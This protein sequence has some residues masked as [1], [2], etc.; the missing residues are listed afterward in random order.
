MKISKYLIAL[1]LL[2]AMACN[3]EIGDGAFSP[4]AGVAEPN[5]TPTPQPVCD[6]EVAISFEQQPVNP[7]IM[8]ILDKSG[9]MGEPLAGYSGAS[10]WDIMRSAIANIVAN[11]GDVVKFGLLMF[12]WGNRCHDGQVRVN[13]SLNAVGTVLQEMNS[14]SPI[15]GTPTHQ[16][17]RQ[18]RD[19]YDNVP[20]N[21]D[22]RIVLLATDGLPV[23]SSIGESVGMI[24]ELQQRGIQTFV[25]GF[26]FGNVSVDGLQQMANAG[27]TGQIYPADSPQQLSDAFDSILGQVTVPS[28]T[29]NLKQ[30][31]K[32][33]ADI[34]VSLA[35][36][37]LVR[38]DENGWMYSS[39]ANSITLNGEACRSVKGG[40]A[41]AIEVDLGCEG[42]IIN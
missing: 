29:F 33:D 30:Q 14:V 12:P 3:S 34:Q 36:A 6:E 23:C 7:D 24:G 21:P 8:L 20:V 31:P 5:P 1:C 40:N 13:P 16:S 28:C 9:S 15:G 22:G 39:S 19:Y 26:G 42:I 18:A 10:K 27:G 2:P 35:G 37:E 25:L 38:D 4:D 32:N 41:A 17:L 11:K